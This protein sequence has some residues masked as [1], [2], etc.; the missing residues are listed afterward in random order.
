ML[1]AIHK[2]GEVA[3]VQRKREIDQARK[4]ASESI[5]QVNDVMMESVNKGVASVFAN[6]RR[7]EQ[8]A[9]SIQTNAKRFQKQTGLWLKMV[10]E[11]NY[12]LKELGD[13]ERWTKTLE[14]DMKNVA[15]ALEEVNKGME[16][17]E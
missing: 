6:Q 8:E 13:V 9:Q 2:E 3:R 10:E 12:Q 11:F 16:E 5:S 7:L 1:S 15:D 14:N 4:D 17:E